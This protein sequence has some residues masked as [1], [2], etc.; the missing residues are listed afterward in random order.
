MCQEC[1]CLCVCITLLIYFLLIW[2]PKAHVWSF[3]YLFLSGPP[4]QCLFRVVD[5]NGWYLNISNWDDCGYIGAESLLFYLLTADINTLKIREMVCT[6]IDSIL[7]KWH[8]I[9]M[10]CVC[11]FNSNATACDSALLSSLIPNE[12]LITLYS[13][14]FTFFFP[15]DFQWVQ[16][17]VCE[18]QLMVYNP[19]PYE[20]RV[21]NM[22]S[23]TYTRLGPIGS[24]KILIIFPTCGDF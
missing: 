16:G 1:M 6:V 11:S 2:F 5:A 18:V 13:A 22:V 20:L 23:E 10:C 19:M 4:P 7:L 3:L 24:Y 21:E 17:A 12:I 14:L 8:L 15:P 9:T